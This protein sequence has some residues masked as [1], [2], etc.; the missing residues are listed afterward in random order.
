MPEGS[1]NCSDMQRLY[2]FEDGLAREKDI[3]HSLFEKAIVNTCDW[4]S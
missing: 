3:N 1:G 4:P 2:A